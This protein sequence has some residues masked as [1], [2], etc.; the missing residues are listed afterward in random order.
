MHPEVLPW[1]IDVPSLVLIA[2]KY[3]FKAR[4]GHTVTQ[5]YMRSP[6]KPAF[7]DTD[8]VTDTDSPD[9][10]TSLR[11]TCAISSR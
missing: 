11:P 9:T 7:Y 8:T 5:S 2:Q 10:P 1:D 3:F 6:K 4:S